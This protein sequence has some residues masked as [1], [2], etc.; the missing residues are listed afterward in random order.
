MLPEMLRQSS[1]VPDV[2]CGRG[3][4]RFCIPVHKRWFQKHRMRMSMWNFEVAKL[5]QREEWRRAMRFE[6]WGRCDFRGCWQETCSKGH[7]H[8][9]DDFR[10]VIC[11]LETL[12]IVSVLW[13]WVCER[14]LTMRGW[15]LIHFPT[16]LG[17][18]WHNLEFQIGTKKENALSFSLK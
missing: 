10:S 3:F 8:V 16:N 5:L 7:T 13:D 9:L 11:T 4:S 14:D 2:L 15:S 17:F 6:V 1:R 12:V 18:P